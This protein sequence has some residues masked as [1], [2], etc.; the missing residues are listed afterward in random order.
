MSR[1]ELSL[2]EPPP[3]RLHAA[4]IRTTAHA[5]VP[6]RRPGETGCQPNRLVVRDVGGPLA[7]VPP[8]RR[9][10]AVDEHA[11]GVPRQRGHQ[12]PGRGLAD[13][14]LRDV[15]SHDVLDLVS[16]H[17]RHLLRRLGLLDEA[18]EEHHV[19]ARHR[20]QWLHNIYTMGRQAI[21]RGRKESPFAYLIPPDQHDPSAAVE[22]LGAR[23]MLTGIQPQMAQAFVELD[24]DLAGIPTARTLREGIARA[25]RI[26]G[27]L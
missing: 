14:R 18:P 22:L 2:R 11:A 1:E 24:I 27:R 26:G 13:Q 7:E 21:E 25:T 3:D 8:T 4:R 19:A 5:G 17:P 9:L 16:E 10:H 20:E 15:A 12:Q 6:R 23:V